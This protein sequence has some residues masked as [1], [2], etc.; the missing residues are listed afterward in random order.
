[1]ACVVLCLAAIPCSTKQEKPVAVCENGKFT[2]YIEDNGVIAFKG[3][4]YA[5]APVGELR[6]KAPQPVEAS[7]A[8]FEATSY[9]CPGLQ[10]YDEGEDASHG[11][12]NE[13][14]LYLNVWTTDLNMR[15]DRPVMDSE[16]YQR[17]RRR[18]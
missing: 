2:G 5:K 1:M 16:E 11:E 18:P 15:K 12:L 6:W 14:C 13:D 10:S 4:P 9:K 8:T 7:D 3:I 17:I